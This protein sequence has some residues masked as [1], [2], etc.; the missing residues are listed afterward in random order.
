MN[1]NPIDEIK[2]IRHRLGAAAGFDVGRI[3]AELRKQQS[4]S[5]RTYVHTPDSDIANNKAINRS[6]E[7]GRSAS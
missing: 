2:Q 4:T 1:L 5:N 3:F 7:A 6:G